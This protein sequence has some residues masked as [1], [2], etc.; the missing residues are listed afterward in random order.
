MCIRDRFNTLSITAG[1]T[2]TVNCKVLMV[3]TDT[4]ITITCGTVVY[5]VNSFIFIDYVPTST[6][7]IAAPS[8]ANV[9]VGAG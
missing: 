8:G 4:P 3:S 1:N 7:V 9:T 5:T 6:A 2:L